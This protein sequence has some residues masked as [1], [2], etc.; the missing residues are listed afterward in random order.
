MRLDWFSFLIG[1]LTLPGLG[2]LAVALFCAW[3]FFTPP[4][5]PDQ[6]SRSMEDE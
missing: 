5:F 3:V 6:Y 1:L 4:L 2:A